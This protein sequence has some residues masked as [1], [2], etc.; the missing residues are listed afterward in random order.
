MVFLRYLGYFQRLKPSYYCVTTRSIVIFSQNGALVLHE[1]NGC[2]K[3]LPAQAWIIYVTLTT[4]NHW[5]ISPWNR[6]EHTQLLSPLQAPAAY[7]F[8][9]DPKAFSDMAKNKSASTR[10][11]QNDQP[12]SLTTDD[13]VGKNKY[14]IDVF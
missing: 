11:D 8:D 3:V 1:I 7:N 10:N 4:Y 9:A 6:L 13:R 2:Y 14:T 5:I 12:L